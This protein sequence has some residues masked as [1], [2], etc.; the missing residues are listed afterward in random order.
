[1]IGCL[2]AFRAIVGPSPGFD[3]S[4]GEKLLLALAGT[5][6]VLA[7][8]LVLVVA[9]RRAGFSMIPHWR[10][11]DDAIRG[12]VKHSTWGVLLHAITGLL[13][14]AAI[15]IGNG[16]AGGVVAYQVAFV[17]FLAPYA[18]LA[19]PVHT[20]ILPELAIEA[21]RDDTAGFAHSVEWTLDRIAVLVVP[22][23]AAMVVFAYPAMRVVAFGN[24]TKTGPSLLAAGVA[25][26]GIGLLPYAAF[27]LFARAFYALGDSRTPAIVAV[28]AA[29]GGVATMIV[30]APLTHGAARVAALGIG[31]TTAYTLGAIGLGVVL[32]RRLAHP[33]A[34]HRFL[35]AVGFAAPLAL[36]VWAAMVAI[37]PQSRAATIGLLALFGA[38]GAACYAFA[39]RR[40][41]PTRPPA[42]ALAEA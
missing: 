5:G 23:A 38:A 18:V 4:N 28:L 41:W 10:H 7:F 42:T 17:F 12:I 16:V 26:L 1:M 3:L 20:A 14:G 25:T 27:L 8:V 24:A 22:V 29:V 9:A 32:R 19:Q 35:V 11:R 37:D 34:P 30:L 13:L 6:G 40:W 21:S 33:F 31:H 2:I 36:I 15:I 39:V